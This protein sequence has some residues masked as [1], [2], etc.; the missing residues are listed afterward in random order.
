MAEEKPKSL[1]E[2]LVVR[3]TGQKTM[4]PANLPFT[5]IADKAKPAAANTVIPWE[6]SD[7]NNN[8]HEKPSSLPRHLRDL[9]PEEIFEPEQAPP[10]VPVTAAMKEEAAA[11]EALNLRPRHILPAAKRRE[12]IY[13]AEHPSPRLAGDFHR[14]HKQILTAFR[15][16]DEKQRS[17]APKTPIGSKYLGRLSGYL[18]SGRTKRQENLNNNLEIILAYARRKN[19][20]TNNEVEALVGVKDRQAANYLRRLVEAGQLVR[21]GRGPLTFYKPAKY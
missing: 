21:G 16:A 3:S 6:N 11:L 19:K 12:M 2:I 14:Y 17:A 4:P 18:R 7:K 5:D 20:I 9:K 1:A 13:P 15:Q 10:A 8:S